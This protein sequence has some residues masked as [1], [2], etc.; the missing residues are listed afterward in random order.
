MTGQKETARHFKDDTENCITASL[1][2]DNKQV[3]LWTTEGG[4][5]EMQATVWLDKTQAVALANYIL[6]L[7]RK[8]ENAANNG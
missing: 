3:L 7:S 2:D 8:I 4:Q 5:S 6:E 1:S